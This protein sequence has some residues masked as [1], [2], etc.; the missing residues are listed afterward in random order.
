MHSLIR[1]LWPEFSPRA[2]IGHAFAVLLFSS[3][4]NMSKQTRKKLRHGSSSLTS[5]SQTWNATIDRGFPARQPERVDLAAVNLRCPSGHPKRAQLLNLVENFR[6][7]SSHFLFIP[8]LNETPWWMWGISTF[9]EHAK[10]ECFSYMNGGWGWLRINDPIR[11]PF[12]PQEIAGAR[13]CPKASATW[14]EIGANGQ[15]R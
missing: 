1:N 5:G 14:K 11:Y 3:I 13:E 7:T 2:K 9:R 6:S 4:F 8:P 15:G 10:W 12:P